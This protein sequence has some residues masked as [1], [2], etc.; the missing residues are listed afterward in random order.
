[1][2]VEARSAREPWG[3]LELDGH[4]RLML[5]EGPRV[6]VVDSGAVAVVSSE[7]VQGAPVGR[8]RFL[9]RLGPGRA[10]FSAPGPAP[11]TRRLFVVPIQSARL[12][13]AAIGEGWPADPG[14]AEVLAGQLDEWVE[15]LARLLEADAPSG[16][17]MRVSAGRELELEEGQVLGPRR[18]S[19]IWM[20]LL[21][22]ALEFMGDGRKTLVGATPFVPLGSGMWLRARGRARISTTGSADLREPAAWLQGLARLH[23]LVLDHVSEQS[24]RENE[25]ELE[26]LQHRERAQDELVERELADL[27][28][29]LRP[30]AA[31]VTGESLVHKA[32]VL[33]GR[34]LGVEILPP[35]ASE[36]PDRQGEALEAIARA[37][38]LRI[39]RV[40]LEGRW[41]RRDCGA[42]LAF[43]G[44]ERHA[45]LALIP[46]RT[47]RY[48]VLDP[49]D[50]SRRPLDARLAAELD[51]EA[52][53]VYRP[54][55]TQ[56]LR[57]L[58]LM[59]FALTGRGSDFA[60]V[61]AAGAAATL[62]GM[63]TPMATALL[64]DHAIPDAD[65]GMLLEI[66][67]GLFFAAFGVALFG[68]ARNLVLL[69]IGIRAEFDTQT[70]IW[71]RLL[72]LRPTFFRHFSSGDLQA[73][74]MAID[75]VG[76][77]L[78]GNVTS[79][80]FTGLLALLNFGLL[81]YFS[82]QLALIALGL[83]A[84]IL[85]ATLGVGAYLQRNVA[86]MIT[87]EGSLFGLV[88][89]LLNGIGKL[90]VAGAEKRAFARWLRD[91]GQQL[92]FWRRARSASDAI[93]VLNQVLPALGLTVLLYFAHAKL[94]AGRGGAAPGGLSLGTFLA[95]NTA[96][97]TF[98][99]G[100]TGLSLS[101]VRFMDVLARTRRVDPILAEVPEADV[102]KADPGRLSGRITIDSLRFRYEE[103]SEDVLED[104]S[105]QVEPGEFVA[106]VG[107]SGSGKSTLLRLLLGFESPTSGTVRYDGQ[108]LSTLD[109][110]AL[111]RQVGVVLQAGAPD[112]SSIFEN[113]SG[114]NPI[115]LDEAWTAAED[116]ELADDVRKM[117]MGM[118]TLVNEGGANLSGGQRQ[119][120][121]IARA[122]A[123]RPRVLFLDEATSALDNRTQEAVSEGL[124]RL[125]VTRVVIAHRLSTIRRADS[126]YV[127]DRG[128]VVQRGTFDELL[129]APGLFRSMMTRQALEGG[130]SAPQ[131]GA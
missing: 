108:D 29:V 41:W 111:R 66:G 9:A 28:G 56:P 19:V 72:R 86:R 76:R 109:V 94:D 47:G 106:V 22:G 57:F 5:D 54:L 17:A 104:V 20:R 118:H 92:T 45:P 97:A 103:G 117:P 113:I 123:M 77:A 34:H 55:P 64:M 88:V 21:E 33:V 124:E 130:G 65:R 62:L 105:L 42:L 131:P 69:R 75:D 50:G 68:F 95:F 125:K 46:Q 36:D 98:L 7:I 99:A 119:R 82:V 60:L 122:L 40:R 10:F 126:I 3:L 116:A 11:R 26:R 78:S 101:L 129:A 43:R 87:I 112:A 100:V 63:V 1:M 8:Q 48:E 16:P 49:A 102:S 84:I 23:G 83:A 128:R 114:G 53:Q 81:C 30:S 52:V 80:L 13:V 89:Q 35:A 25:D 71:D 39:R 2:K 51:A 79:T 67:L 93:A 73:R 96:F 4:K 127:L 14:P 6:Y 15:R 58:D 38:H 12:R 110:L 44:D 107:S 27:V 31:P 120:L 70:A 74:V 32:M 24:E 85:V 90:R 91:Y 115:T 61:F 37:S 18:R 59:R 121:L